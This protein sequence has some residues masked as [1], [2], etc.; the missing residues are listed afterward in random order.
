[1][2]TAYHTWKRGQGGQITAHFGRTEF[3][4]P[5]GCPDQK[6]A[7][8]LVAKLEE[9]RAA[10]GEPIRVTSGYRCRAYQEDL[11][12][13]GYETAKGIS[14]H[15]LGNAADIT[16]DAMASLQALVVK[17]FKAVGVAR[18]FI[19]V[20]LREDTTRRWFYK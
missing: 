4:C 18:T 20:D 16:T 7:V 10:L 6:I 17:R 15:E 8:N 19:H 14:Q 12:R 13:R 2:S 3:E 9:V 5:C 11:A 1:M